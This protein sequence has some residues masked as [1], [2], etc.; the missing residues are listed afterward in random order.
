MREPLVTVPAPTSTSPLD[1][2]LL[3]EMV[4]YLQDYAILLLDRRGRILSADIGGKQ[5]KGWRTEEITGRGHA[6]FY[7]SADARAGRPQDELGL[8]DEYGRF[9]GQSWRA[10]RDGSR[11]WANVVITPVHDSS[12]TPRGYGEV[13]RDVT[14]HQAAIHA[15]RR[16]EARFRA[17]SESATDA[18]LSVNAAGKIISWNPA[19]ARLY[20]YSA[21]E[22]IGMDHAELSPECQ[23]EGARRLLMQVNAPGG[24]QLD[25]YVGTALHADGR[26]IPIEATFGCWESEGSLNF[27]AI[28]RDI[29]ER[30][31]L[32]AALQHLADHDSLTGLPN[33]RRL[34][35]EIERIVTEARRYDRRA[36]LLVLDLD[37]FKE[38][39]DRLGHSA[40]DELL[41]Q[42]G[43]LLSR[44]VRESDIVARL[45]G[46]EFG[47]V[48]HE[49]D[50]EQARIV[51]EKLIEAV[52]QRGIISRGD[53]HAPV[54]ASIGIALLEPAS[55]QD[56]EE[57]LRNADDA[58]YDAKAQ[59]GN[60]HAVHDP[61][62]GLDSGPAERRSWI[63]RLRDALAH[64]RF[65]LY[66]QPIVGIRGQGC[67][68]YELL[69]RLHGQD[70]E[71]IAPG[72]FLEDAERFDLIGEIDRWVLARA[73]ALLHDHHRVGRDIC[74]TVN[75]SH[76]TMNDRAIVADLSAMLRAHT[77]PRDQL[78]IEVNEAAAIVDTARA[79]ELAHDL[80]ALGCGFALDDFGSGFASFHFLKHL[81]FDYL[82]IDGGFIAG[83]VGT[84]SD[85]LVVRAVVDIA[86][87]LGSQTIA[88][89]V[90]D[91]ATVEMLGEFG[92]DYGQGYHLGR[93][94][95][96]AARLPALQAV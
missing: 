41:V 78:V 15:L 80:R 74:L 12:G 89:C 28:V 32:D 19:A 18:I 53:T 45:G 42:I 23:R 92:V 96:L 14:D 49:A 63:V 37:G 10:R 5:F 58:M 84:P 65:E 30:K 44:V 94:E 55:E 4:E 72:A 3:S 16:S 9:E 86:R 38:V 73:V 64:D 21:E 24:A 69:L 26:K 46:D 40:G 75:I 48:I 83:L 31:R 61:G 29:T 13:I 67:P 17:V 7:P 66:A 60:T 6:I 11:Y 70:D 59:G 35:A 87:G 54:T 1:S 36:A 56:A 95:P 90:G 93:P 79:A 20:G 77:V 81:A 39:N 52:R 51:A 25:P 8:A 82:K 57:L 27:S 62:D 50:R 33:R 68:R 85:Q 22:A 2:R 88:E 91:D 71:L 76:K 43:T 47:V 34:E